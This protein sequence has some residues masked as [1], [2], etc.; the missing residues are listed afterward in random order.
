MLESTNLDAASSSTKANPSG[1]HTHTYW[2]VH[3]LVGKVFTFKICFIY[4]QSKAH[5]SWCNFQKIL[6]LQVDAPP[7]IEI[8][9]MLLTPSDGRK[10]R[11][12]MR[13]ACGTIALP[14]PAHK[15]E[16]RRPTDA[17]IIARA[18]IAFR[19][20]VLYLRVRVQGPGL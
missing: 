15:S 3:P 4:C 2:A 7:S 9:I 10:G 17:H 18:L 13:H 1:L 12:C 8:R 19:Y 6:I 5:Y 16:Q 11:A 14:P 20:G